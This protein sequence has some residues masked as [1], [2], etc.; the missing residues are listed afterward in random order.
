[1][2]RLDSDVPS[3]GQSFQPRIVANGLA[4]AVVWCDARVRLDWEIYFDRSTDG[5]T[6]WL[7]AEVPLGLL[8]GNASYPTLVASGPALY[9]AWI[10]DVAGPVDTVAA[11]RSLDGGASWLGAIKV[12]QNAPIL[13]HSTEPSLAVSGSALELVWWAQVSGIDSDVYA[14]RSTDNGLSWSP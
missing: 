11:N 2:V 5:G 13:Q 9:A 7:N 8:A 14:S 3:A 1:D 4:V 10:E 6:T 12:N